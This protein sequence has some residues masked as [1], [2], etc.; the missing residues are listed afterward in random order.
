MIEEAKRRAIELAQRLQAM[1]LSR[2]YKRLFKP[3]GIMTRDAEIVLADLARAL[4]ANR[5]TFHSD[6]QIMAMREGSRR[7]WLRISRLLN[8][9]EATVQKLVEIDNGE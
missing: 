8:L 1:R 5:S 2:H 3:D 4:Y 6:A 7:V 9:D